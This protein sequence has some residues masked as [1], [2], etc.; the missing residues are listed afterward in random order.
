RKQHVL[1]VAILG[2]LAQAAPANRPEKKFYSDDP[3]W[4]EPAPRTVRQVAVR[5]V[6]DIYDFLENSYLTPNREGKIAKRG[7]RPA[8]DVNTLGEVPD[9]AWYTNRHWLRRMSIAELQRGP[10]NTTPPNPDQPWQIVGAKS[11]GVTP[12]F[13]IEDSR[14]TRYL[15]K[16]DPPRFPELCSVADVIGSKF[17]YALGY[18][19]PEN[20]VVH[21]RRDNLAISEG[22]NWRD[23]TGRKHPLTSKAL[24]DLLKTQPKGPNGDYR[25]LA[26]RWIEGKVVG[27]FSYRGMRNDDPNDTIPHQDRRMLRGLAIFSS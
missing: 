5:E 21:F 3:L 11:D 15:L 26:S 24:D 25:A 6:D 22:V 20:Y 14:K 4:R 27:P 18:S 7:P 19:T 9:N 23:R 2:G 17:F 13:V 16:F 8:L 10:G 12:G 1:I